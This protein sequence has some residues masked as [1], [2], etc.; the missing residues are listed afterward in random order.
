MDSDCARFR[1]FQLLRPSGNWHPLSRTLKGI[2]VSRPTTISVASLA[3]FGLVAGTTVAATTPA[4]ASITDPGATSSVVR[5]AHPGGVQI[6]RGVRGRLTRLTTDPDHPITVPDATLAQESRPS[7]LAAARAHAHALAGSLGVT[8]ADK[9]LVSQYVHRVGNGDNAVRF[10]QRINGISVFAGR[11]AM[12]VDSQGSLQAVSSGLASAPGDTS[13]TV[14]REVAETVARSAAARAGRTVASRVSAAAARPVIYSPGLV[15]LSEGPSRMAWSVSTIS[16]A[17]DAND[18]VLVDARTAAVLLVNARTQ[19]ALNRI[20]CDRGN[21][22]VASTSYAAFFASVCD[23][24]WSSRNEGDPASGIADVNGAYS[25][26]GRTSDFYGTQLTTSVDLTSLIGYADSDVTEWATS[27]TGTVNQLRASTNWCDALEFDP[28][29]PMD[30][31]FF[32]NLPVINDHGYPGGAIFFGTGYTNPDDVV[33]HE[34]THGVTAATSGLLY[35]L[36]SGAINESMSDVFGEL[37]DQAHNDGAGD[38]ADDA[39]WKIGEDISGGP[40]RSMSDPT[41]LLFG[42]RQPDKMTS[43]NWYV[44]ANDAAHDHGGVHSNSGVGNKVAYLIGHG[45]T[46][47][48]VNVPGLGIDQGSGQSAG[49]TK[50][51]DLYWRVENTLLPGASYA[52]LGRE[53]VA[54]A[55][56]LGWSGANLLTVKNAVHATQLDKLATRI[57]VSATTIRAGATLRITAKANSYRGGAASGV[58]MRLYRRLYPSTSYA[59]YGT[60]TTN[61]AGAITW[62]VKPSATSRY[63]VA[64]VAGSVATAAAVSSNPVTVNPVVST[65]SSNYR[66]TKRKYFVVTGKAVPVGGRVT[67]QRLSSGRWV[68]VTTAAV[69][70][71][72]AYAFRIRYSSRGYK[73]LRVMDYATT[74]HGT[75]VSRTLKI[76]VV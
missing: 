57:S 23:N 6:S 68:S 70:S 2:S 72:G 19:R 13:M 76:H 22:R 48:G 74:W 38:Q 64:I 55:I 39:T 25:N 21:A 49:I 62:N 17:E 40:I 27:G 71:R 7:P 18:E 3:I 47:N 56:Q 53:L 29:C 33:A 41:Q 50:M 31:A 11:V 30:N 69:F 24:S 52:D 20:V 8:S 44:G 35:Q 28:S 73:Y 51:G 63:Y 60:G 59:F 16:G 32:T 4:G 15:G 67:L 66:P 9:D 58:A 34:L 10:A 42:T 26:L 14:S 5:S 37:V 46:F 36:E 45:G 65:A 54:A 75:G 1:V 12:I 43:T 61:S